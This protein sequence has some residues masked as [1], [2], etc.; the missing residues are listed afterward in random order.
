MLRNET[1]DGERRRRTD[2]GHT[3]NASFSRLR[4]AMRAGRTTFR[5]A[6][7]LS[8]PLVISCGV[9][10]PVDPT[11]LPDKTREVGD[12]TLVD[13][14][15]SLRDR[16][17]I[18]STMYKGLSEFY[19]VAPSGRSLSYADGVYDDNRPFWSP[20]DDIADIIGTHADTTLGLVYWAQSSATTGAWSVAGGNQPGGLR[21]LSATSVSRMAVSLA[22]GS[23]AMLVNIAGSPGR[24]DVTS[25]TGNWSRGGDLDPHWVAEDGSSVIVALSD[26]TIGLLRKPGT[27]LD[28]MVAPIPGR[29]IRV[30]TTASG[31]RALVAEPRGDSTVFHR[32]DPIGGTATR[33]GA[34]TG[35]WRSPSLDRRSGRAVVWTT[36]DGGAHWSLVLLDADS[37]TTLLQR[38]GDGTTM[39]PWETLYSNRR[40]AWSWGD[41]RLRIT[42][43]D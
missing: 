42:A 31:V 36:V 9:G 33:L 2:C 25:T 16:R 23:V 1:Y 7:T 22:G 30:A 32:W 12:V 40:I 34:V 6:V 11:T 37:A 41:R 15:G 28:A 17:A 21:R 10:S 19:F 18:A 27:T 38:A 43:V 29:V 3:F 39:R 35:V 5:I 4:P 24:L 13:A 14:K 26:S 20:N 8:A